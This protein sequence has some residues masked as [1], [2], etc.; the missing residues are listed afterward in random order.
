M[1]TVSPFLPAANLYGACSISCFGMAEN[2]R[3]IYLFTEKIV[4]SGLVT[5]CLFAIAPTNLLPSFVKATTDGV[6][7]FPS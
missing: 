3:P 5:A 6:V 1:T 4:F 2:F 7:L